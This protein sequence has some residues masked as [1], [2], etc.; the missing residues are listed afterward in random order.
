MDDHDQEMNRTVSMRRK[1]YRGRL[2]ADPEPEGR[3]YDKELGRE[4]TLEP[5]LMDDAHQEDT[6]P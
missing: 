4:R 3:I 2:E 5:E 6:A 1:V